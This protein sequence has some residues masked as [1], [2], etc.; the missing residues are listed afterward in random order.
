MIPPL[1]YQYFLFDAWGG[2]SVK[3]SIGDLVA[4]KKVNH[5]YFADNHYG[6][7]YA[8]SPYYAPDEYWDEYYERAKNRTPAIAIIMDAKENDFTGYYEA[9][10]LMTYRIM[11]LNAEEDDYMMSRWFYGDE[12][13]LLSKINRP[14]NPAEVEDGQ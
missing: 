1:P 12:L 11:W 8:L 10:T 2:I 13:R 9:N 3:F 14:A 6:F 4:E 7:G 5:W